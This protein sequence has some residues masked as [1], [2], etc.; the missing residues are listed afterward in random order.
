[1]WVKNREE[2]SKMRVSFLATII[3][4]IALAVTPAMADIVYDLSSD[5][6][7]G[8]CGTAP[9]GTVTLSDG[10]G[11]VHVVVALNANYKFVNT[12]FDGSVM[13]NLTGNP[14]ITVSNISSGWSLFNFDGG[15]PNST[16]AATGGNI[17]MDGLGY[18]DY[19]MVCTACGSGGSNPQPSPMSFD[20]TAAGGLTIARFAERSR[21]NS[22][23]IDPA[24]QFFGVDII[25]LLT[26]NTGPVD[27]SNPGR[28]PQEVTPEPSAL[29]LLGSVGF[30]LCSLMRKR[31]AA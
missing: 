25:N 22:D 17:H 21:D 14:T 15:A 23:N 16:I 27:A 13:W 4:M 18:F 10:G 7:T 20:V 5:H 29:V 9:F 19:A 26:G 30:A 8:G 28:T 3:G 1:V 12:G 6:C 31:R 24:G 11:T 2:Q